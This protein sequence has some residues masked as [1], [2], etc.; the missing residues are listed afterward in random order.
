MADVIFTPL[1]EHQAPNSRGC[2]VCVCVGV[3]CNYGWPQPAQGF[4]RTIL[5]NN[6]CS[7]SRPSTFFQNPRDL[8]PA[9][10]R[11]RYSCPPLDYDILRINEERCITR[12][13]MY[14]SVPSRQALYIEGERGWWVI[15][16]GCLDLRELR[17]ITVL[18]WSR[19]W[20]PTWNAVTSAH[21][22][23]EYIQ[24]IHKRIHI[25]QYL[26]Q[27]IHERKPTHISD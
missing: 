22:F 8:R 25:A 18:H 12:T 4:W 26:L 21:F 27:Y 3:A 16:F 24:F 23:L 19:L 14:T 5:A 10:F 20:D 7:L 6:F 17:I 15:L 11:K 9:L 2:V 13:R 1:R